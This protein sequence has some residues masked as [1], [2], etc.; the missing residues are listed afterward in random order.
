MI[1]DPVVVPLPGRLARL[2][3]EEHVP[4]EV[5]TH[6]P[7]F[8]AQ[9]AAAAAHVPGRELAKVVVLRDAE[10]GS[11]LV[12]LPATCLLDMDAVAAVTGRRHPQ[13]VSRAD[14]AGLFPDCEH[15]AVPPFGA[16]YGLPLFVDACLARA[17]HVFFTAGSVRQVF[18]VRGED[19]LRLVQPEPGDFCFHS[20]RR[21]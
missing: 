20:T 10:G 6:Q 3:Q 14:L 1:A 11:F 17:R 18:G 5:L 19:F 9:E 12:A 21:H 16:L 2:F 7:A 8:T 15:G 4:Y 13:L